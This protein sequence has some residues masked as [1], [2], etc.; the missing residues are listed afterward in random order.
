MVLITFII[1]GTVSS[2]VIDSS[3]IS[4]DVTNFFGLNIYTFISFIIICFLFLSFFYLSHVFIKISLQ[5]SINLY[6]RLIIIA[7]AGLLFLLAGINELPAYVN[8]VVLAWLLIY[9]L[10]IESRQKDINV[11]MLHSSFFI[12]WAILLMGSATALI[13]YQNETKELE[14]RKRIAENQDLLT[15]PSGEYLLRN[16]ITN[17]SNLFLSQNFL[18]FYNEYSNKFLK[19]SLIRENFSGYLNKYDTRIYTYNNQFQPLFNDDSASYDIIKSIIDNQ[20]KAT[21]TPDLY[22][23]ENASD[24]FGYIYERK[25]MSRDTTQLGYIL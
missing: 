2:L 7:M 17:F 25:V 19:D 3:K 4:F 15:D 20:G 12:I 11:S 18:R 16:G 23:Y 22:Y 13:V 9:T 10:I 8:V 5:S 14:I 24:R 1:A 21:T 6:W